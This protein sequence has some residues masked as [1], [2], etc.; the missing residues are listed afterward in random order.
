LNDAN[1]LGNTGMAYD[2]IYNSFS[3]TERKTIEDGAFKPE[4]GFFLQKT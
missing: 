2:L 3:P 4:G 1:W